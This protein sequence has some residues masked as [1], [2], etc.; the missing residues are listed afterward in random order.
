M[1]SDNERKYADNGNSVMNWQIRE[2]V[3]YRILN[4]NLKIRENID[5]SDIEYRTGKLEKVSDDRMSNT[6]PE[7]KGQ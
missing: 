5:L 6:G 1:L 4:T 2:N 3:D 7:L